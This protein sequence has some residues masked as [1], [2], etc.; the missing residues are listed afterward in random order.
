MGDDDHACADCGAIDCEV[1]FHACLAADF[2]D[3]DYGVVHHLVVS[4][5]GLQHGW[6]PA[7]AEPAM[8]DFLIR[9][10]DRPPG[11]HDRRR[12]RAAVDGPVQVRARQPRSRNIEW[13]HHVRDV[14]RSS[15]ESYAATVRRWAGSIATTLLDG[16]HAAERRD[17]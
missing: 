1:S 2:T 5:Y 15:P 13:E 16:G 9:H 10:L 6:Y 4:A 11:D 12:I 17:V 14:D 3:P 7:E 8:V